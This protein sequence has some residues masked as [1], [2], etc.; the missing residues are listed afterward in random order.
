MNSPRSGF[1][2]HCVGVGLCLVMVV[3]EALQVCRVE[4]VAAFGQGRDVVDFVG[5]APAAGVLAGGC[6]AELVGAEPA[7]AGAGL[8]A[9][10]AFECWSA[11]AWLAWLG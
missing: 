5:K 2:S 9:C 1:A 10:R 4:F 11:G 6:G 8:A 7:P 3:A